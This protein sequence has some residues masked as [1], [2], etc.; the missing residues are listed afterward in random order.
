ME[1][2]TSEVEIFALFGITMLGIS[3]MVHEIGHAVA[4]IVQGFEVLEINLL[5]SYV[6]CSAS[7]QII[8]IMGGG[9]GSIT[10]LLFFCVKRIRRFL[11]MSLGFFTAALTQFLL[12]MLE[13]FWNS[14]Y[15]AHD[16]ENYALVFGLIVLAALG[17]Y[18]R[19]KLKGWHS[20]KIGKTDLPA[21]RN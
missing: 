18:F 20:I 11:P 13:G 9:L 14:M 12:M 17:L 10:M 15:R 7:N 21:G 3:V 19:S 5:L 8:W 4:C 6:R 2:K 16:L 1:R